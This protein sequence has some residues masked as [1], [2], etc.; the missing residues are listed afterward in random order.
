MFRESLGRGGW[1]G[2]ESRVCTEIFC[3]LALLPA[4]GSF[5]KRDWKLVHLTF[6]ESEGEATLL[7]SQQKENG[8]TTTPQ[9]LGL[10][11]FIMRPST[12]H[13]HPDCLLDIPEVSSSPF[14][15]EE[16]KPER[17]EDS[18]KATHLI[19]GQSPV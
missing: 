3:S 17:L 6:E 9:L 10:P 11:A 19:S 15:R 8:S 5:R 18:P 13:P 2:G 16:R 7:H 14:H 1:A 12:P 4:R